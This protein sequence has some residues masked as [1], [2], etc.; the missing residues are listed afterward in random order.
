M[1]YCV[2]SCLLNLLPLEFWQS[3]VRILTAVVL[4]N[5]LNSWHGSWLVT[6]EPGDRK[7]QSLPRAPLASVDARCG[8]R[9]YSGRWSS[10]GFS[11]SARLAATTTRC[12]LGEQRGLHNFLPRKLASPPACLASLPVLHPAGVFGNVGAPASAA[13]STAVH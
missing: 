8:L 3:P 9:G 11:C 5:F 2:T 6:A 13:T 4:A 12:A 10:S 1:T 7:G